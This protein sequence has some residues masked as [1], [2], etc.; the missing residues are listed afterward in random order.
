MAG[1]AGAQERQAG[2]VR[3]LPLPPPHTQVRR[4]GGLGTGGWEG[5]S[6]AAVEGREG[7][8]L[9]ATRGGLRPCWEAGRVV[10]PVLLTTLASVVLDELAV[11]AQHHLE[12]VGRRLPG[13][14]RQLSASGNT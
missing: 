8:S 4:G 9:A 13:E 11:L 7:R 12:R 3:A 5:S 1:W 2:Q 14:G 6:L 10:A